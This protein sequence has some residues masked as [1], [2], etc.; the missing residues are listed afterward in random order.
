MQQD[1]NWTKLVLNSA[2]KKTFQSA[3]KKMG[4][5]EPLSK[6]DLVNC[7]RWLLVAYLSFKIVTPLLY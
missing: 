6:S 5:S 2:M 4:Y 7:L 3:S 1:E